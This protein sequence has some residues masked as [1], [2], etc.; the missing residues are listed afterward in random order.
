MH[1]HPIRDVDLCRPPLPI[2]YSDYVRHS[3]DI[4]RLD[5]I[6]DR[7]LAAEFESGGQR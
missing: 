2:A 5:I 6:T 1:S 4:Y 3:L 7:G